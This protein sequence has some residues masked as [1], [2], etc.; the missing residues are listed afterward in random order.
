AGL[1]GRGPHLVVRVIARISSKALHVHGSPAR[2]RLLETLERLV[3]RRA[4]LVVP[5]GTFTRRLAVGSGAPEDRIVVL[6]CLTRWQTADAPVRRRPDDAPRVI[7]AGRF[8][9]EKGFDVLLRALADVGRSLADVTLDLAGDGPER[10][11]L[12]HLAQELGVAARVRFH[13]WLPAGQLAELFGSA[14]VAVLPSR[15]EEGLGMVLVEAG[16]AGCALV[17]SDLGGIR[18]IVRHGESGL[19]VEPD[20]PTALAGAL[21]RLLI[22]RG[23]A[24]QLGAA[25]RSA[26]LAYL[27]DRD[28]A[29]EQLRGAMVALA[30]HDRRVARPASLSG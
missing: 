14:D 2:A 28:T 25:A 30:Q 21:H 8:V 26:A 13:G 7:A 20:D 1:L 10:L 11:R 19:L 16:I 3:L 24:R 12:H 22:D 4:R 29:L 27:A 5:M 6:P 9:P 18:D 23:E 15:V 17:G